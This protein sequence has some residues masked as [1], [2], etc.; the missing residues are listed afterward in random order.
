MSNAMS[1]KKFCL[2]IQN[3]N[4]GDVIQKWVNLSTFWKILAL[5]ILGSSPLMYSLYK[6]K[7]LHQN[8][9]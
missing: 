5:G 4:G 1:K 8:K 6:A 9:K 3:A 7:A 2:Y